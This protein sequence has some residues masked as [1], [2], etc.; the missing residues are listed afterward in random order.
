MTAKNGVQ[1]W[2]RAQWVASLATIL[3]ALAPVAVASPQDEPSA[4]PVATVGDELQKLRA[5]LQQWGA[6]GREARDAAIERLLAM[7]RAE[8]HALLHERLRQAGDDDDRVRSAIVTALQRQLLLTAEAQFGGAAGSVRERL[9]VDWLRALAPAWRGANGAPDADAS[10][11]T[12]GD[13]VRPLAR[14]ALLR[15]PAA[16]LDPA[17]RVALAEAA[18]PEQLDLLRCLADMRNT[19]FAVTIADR[20]DAGDDA[21]RASAREALQLL[22]CPDQPI[23][24]KA[25]FAAWRAANQ[26]LRYV[27]LVERAARRGS[28]SVERQQRELTRLR[29]AAA[30]DVVQAHVARTPGVDW[31]AVRGRVVAEDAAVLDA[32]LELLQQKLPTLPDDASP[33]RQSFAKELLQRFHAESPAELKRRAR[34]LEVA[35]YLGRAED[36]E[37]AAELVRALLDATAVDDADTRI[38]AIHGLRRYPTAESRAR[39]VALAGELL[40][41]TPVASEQL[42]A[43][44]GTLSARTP[45]R[46]SAPSP[47]DPD[48]AD[49]LALVEAFCRSDEQL[50]LR[51]QGLALAQTLDARDQRVPEVFDLLLA[52]IRDPALPVKFR[53]ACAIH[54][55]G[56]R[57]DSAFG[58]AWLKAELE[59]LVD[60][61]PELRRHA[62]EA[63]ANLASVAGIDL[64]KDGPATI[65]AL[66]DRLLVEPD[67]AVFRALVESLQAC[68]REPTMPAAAIGALQLAL[69]ELG[70][71]VPQHQAFRVEPLLQALAM[72]GADPRADRGHWLPACQVLLE[73]KRRQSLRLIL[74]SQGAIHLAKDVQSGNS[75]LADR[76]GQVLLLVI[77]TGSLKP[78]RE[79]WSSTDELAQEFRDVRTAFGALDSVGNK[80]WAQYPGVRVLRLEV[81]LAAGK[82]QDAAQRAA[83]WLAN[84]NDTKPPTTDADRDRMR[85]LAAEAHLLLA[86]PDAARRVFD[87]RTDDAPDDAAARD[88]ESRIARALVATDLAGAVELFHRVLRRTPSDDPTY[89]A[90]ALDWMTHRVRLDPALRADTLREAERY[91]ALFRAAD[92]PEELRQQFELFVGRR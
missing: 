40:R 82:P 51:E 55:Q 4:A 6:E 67:P 15:V 64:S 8:A 62:A 48:K 56:W 25:Q 26:D 1:R 59:L 27:D 81:D 65:T 50:G 7:P 87:E 3:S 76:A 11:D 47:T 92:C 18:V 49:W 17:A 9:L 60:A 83:T 12:V 38:A 10:G 73:H 22:V 53:T 70:D 89:R 2:C 45:A 85:L 28:P 91:A 71:P 39:L 21:V 72:I 41:A 79:S 32:C 58:K 69:A 35:A 13:P 33:A 78:A 80:D 66:R 34:L 57:N 43:V 74:T 24:T 5:Q 42:Q 44:L 61:A 90:R 68:G 84:G 29:V 19:L 88:L 46:W 23:E 54:L 20:L 52:L 77:Q 75:V 31:A 37:L 30:R 36:T 63:L 86:K 16:E 14:I